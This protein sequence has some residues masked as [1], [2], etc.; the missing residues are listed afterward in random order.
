MISTN[1]EKRINKAVEDMYS[2]QGIEY[3][4]RLMIQ[5]IDL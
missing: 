5:G 3:K 2:K 1:V 4:K